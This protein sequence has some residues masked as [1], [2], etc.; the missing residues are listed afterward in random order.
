MSCNLTCVDFTCLAPSC[1]CLFL[2]HKFISLNVITFSEFSTM[3]HC[4]INIFKVQFHRITPLH[5]WFPTTCRTKPNTSDCS[6]LGPWLPCCQFLLFLCSRVTF[7]TFCCYVT[8]SPYRNHS[9]KRAGYKEK[10]RDRA[11]GK[12]DDR[13]RSFILMNSNDLNMI[14]GR[15]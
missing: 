3:Y 13:R 9:F 12:K 4:L 14:S 1:Y 11:K 5:Y 7:Q 15:D 10:Y 6:W 8:A 2:A